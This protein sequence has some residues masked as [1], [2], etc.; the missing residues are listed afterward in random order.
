MGERMDFTSGGE[1]RE[2]AEMWPTPKS[3]AGDALLGRLDGVKTVRGS[4]DAYEVATFSPVVVQQDDA[5]TG[6]VTMAVA[7]STTLRGRVGVRDVGRCFVLVFR[8]IAA[9]K[10]YKLFD[11][12]EQP[13]EM[14]RQALEQLGAP[15]DVQ[16]FAV[17]T[18]AEPGLPF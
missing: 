6:H 7:V 16:E 4:K 12:Y 18:I 10:R 15:V 5:R 13:V 1:P 3:N 14:L 17:A 2:S 11:V 9:G 8:G